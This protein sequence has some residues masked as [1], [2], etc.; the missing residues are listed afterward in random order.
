MTPLITERGI[1]DKQSDDESPGRDLEYVLVDANAFVC[2]D[3]IA[4]KGVMG[5][6]KGW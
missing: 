3:D 5:T 4:A 2:Y 6:G 1:A